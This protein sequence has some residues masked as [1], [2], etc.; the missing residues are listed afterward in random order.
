MQPTL[1]ENNDVHGECQ[2]LNLVNRVLN[3]GVETQNRT[4]VSTLSIIGS[5]MEFDLSK[6]FPLLTTKKMFWKAICEELLFFIS[7]K[8]DAKLLADKGVHIWDGNSSRE[9]LNSIGMNDREVGDLGPVYGFQWRH[10]GSEYEGHKFDHT[11]R[12]V[13]QLAKCI[14]QIKTN[15]NSR[16]IV[17]S[18]WNPMDISMMV[19]PPCHMICHFRVIDGRLSCTMFQRSA[20]LGLGVPFNI[21]SYALL[22]H[23]I[24]NHCGLQVGKLVIM[25]SDTHI[26]ST[27]IEALKPQLSRTPL[28]F[29]QIKIHK[30]DMFQC[31]YSDIEI[32]G[33]KSHP[34]IAMKMAV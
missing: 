5:M 21:A 1:T 26:Y 2:Y 19:L 9:Y 24:A 32:V 29:P 34:A 3:E 28:P 14:K 30:L 11:G 27:H 16:Q 15:P 8:T 23:L 10:F 17:M 31:Q 4:G 18:A 25:M 13:D 7:G 22:T 20:D 6:G 33:Y 12:G